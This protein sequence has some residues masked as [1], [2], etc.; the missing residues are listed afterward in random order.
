MGLDA[1]QDSTVLLKQISKGEREAFARFYDIH[2]SLVYTF[3]VRI[4]HQQ[5]DAEELVQDIFIQV[6]QKAST[7]SPQR[8]APE[9]WLITMTRSRAL[10]RVRSKRRREQRVTL[11]DEPEQLEESAGEPPKISDLGDREAAQDA[12]ASLPQ[13]QRSALQ[14]AYFE[15]LTQSEI[16]A[17]LALPLGTVK[18]RIRDGLQYLRGRLKAQEGSVQS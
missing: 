15:G 10:D 9:A 4:L 6:W 14:L 7:Y 13:E 5:A 8:G 12:L 16:A 3:A 2:A 18:T 1:Q 17:R 11:V